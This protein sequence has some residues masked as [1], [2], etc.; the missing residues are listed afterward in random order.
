MRNVALSGTTYGESPSGFDLVAKIYEIL[1]ARLPSSWSLLIAPQEWEGSWNDQT[2]FV[3]QITS[4]SGTKATV[5]VEVRRQIDP[6]DVAWLADYRRRKSNTDRSLV[7]A[8]YVSPRTRELLTAARIGYAD[9]TGNFRW[10]LEEPMVFI[11]LTGANS[12]PWR[13]ER[14]LLS[15]KGSVAGRVVRALCDFVP[16]YKI[17]ELAERSGTSLGSTSRVVTFAEREALLARDKRGTVVDVKWEQLIRR[18]TEDYSLTRSNQMRSFLEP[19]GVE[20]LLRKLETSEVPHSITGSFAAMRV[21]PIASARLAVLYI[22][23]IG[24]ANGDNIGAAAE[25]LGLRPVESG[26]NALLA[27]PFDPVVFD[28]TTKSDG[29]TYAALSQ[30][31]ADL[32]T[33]PGR[34]PA[35]GE[36][37]LKWMGE[38]QDAWRH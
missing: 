9:A 5:D 30:V 23:N 15:L 20:A 34:S 28:R 7:I 10:E 24:A 19:R 35:E 6:K 36:E 22:G 12:N 16:P 32:L 37:L 38:N 13:G 18:W 11:T 3:L 27:Q 14:P 26:T 29:I 33:G 8:P 17:R 4:G 21:A 2:D 1:K 31:A 25:Q